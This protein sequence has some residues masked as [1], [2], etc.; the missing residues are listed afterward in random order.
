MCVPRCK[1]IILVFK[2]IK[3]TEA[4]FSDLQ[5]STSKSGIFRTLSQPFGLLGSIVP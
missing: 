2:V 5:G 4:P 1:S 3:K